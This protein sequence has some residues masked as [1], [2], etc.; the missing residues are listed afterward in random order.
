[1]PPGEK[2]TK[3]EVVHPFNKLVRIDV[4]A[5]CRLPRGLFFE[6]CNIL[7]EQKGIL[8]CI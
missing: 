3:F 2:D 1:M 5:Y 4:V 8:D 6:V 7:I